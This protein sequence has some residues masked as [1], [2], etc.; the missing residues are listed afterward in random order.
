MITLITGENTFENERAVARIIADS[1]VV[2]E[3]VDGSELELRQLPDLLMG[4]TLF[5]AQRLVIIK[6]LSENKTLWNEMEQWIGRISPDV[7]LVVVEAKPD[8]RTKTYKLFQKQATVYESKLW[9][10]RD[11][12]KAEQWT[13][14]EAKTLGFT[15]DKKSARA[16]V[17]RI[18]V[19]QWE[20]YRALE[21][22]TVLP[23][24]TPAIIE[25]TI[26]AHPSENVFY[27]F[28]TALKGDAAKVRDMVKV[29]RLSEDPYRLFGLMS[30]Q[31]LQLATLSLAN[32]PAADVAKEL[33]AH[34]FALSKLAPYA[35]KY[36][37]AKSKKLLA[38][39]AKADEAMKTS[40]VDP[41]L[42]VEEA[43]VKVCLL[44]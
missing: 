34:P 28:E 20:L 27:L 1:T 33:G 6:T 22:L 15:L 21:K 17:A 36:D 8:K 42:A 30:T 37:H 31:A 35:K 4:G 32:K 13:A 25:E 16:L 5:A 43:L 14:N 29:L 44:S 2:P 18:G 9:G 7:H 38:A 11:A 3:K 41:W 23:D 12:A 40:A 19:D 10:E 26:E 39:F 24:V